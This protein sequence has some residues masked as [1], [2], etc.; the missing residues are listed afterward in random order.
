[1]P[2]PTRDISIL[3]NAVERGENE[4]WA[5]LIPTVYQ[6]LKI[7]ARSTLRKERPGHTLQA[8]ALVHEL[9][10]R[11]IKRKDA[12][13][14]N[15]VHFYRAATMALNW[16]LLDHAR[17]K[18]RRLGSGQIVVFSIDA[19]C[20]PADPGGYS[21]RLKLL[22]LALKRLD[23]DSRLSRKCQVVN[24]RFFMGMTNRE[25]AEELGV[26]LN[27]VKNDWVYAKAWLLREIEKYDRHG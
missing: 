24:M 8:T 6:E 11:L 23:S 16:I 25:I 7:L 27:T 1:M 14:S 17:K 15:R 21:E 20:E 12:N 19:N 26:S 9:F 3:L 10:L 4:A 13:W 5:K 18:G 2:N 22:D